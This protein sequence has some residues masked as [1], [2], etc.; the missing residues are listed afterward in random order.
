MSEASV[1]IEKLV[2]TNVDTRGRPTRLDN[3]SI[4]GSSTAA[5]L[6]VETSEPL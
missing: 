3:E 5:A 2:Q 1:K 6:T 4:D